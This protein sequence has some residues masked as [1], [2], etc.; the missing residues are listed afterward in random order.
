[1][2]EVDTETVMF[3]VINNTNSND[4]FQQYINKILLHYL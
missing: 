2:N 4:I 3:R 1:M